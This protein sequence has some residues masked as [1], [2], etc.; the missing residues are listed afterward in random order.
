MYASEVWD[1]NCKGRNLDIL[2][3]TAFTLPLGKGDLENVVCSPPESPR[4]AHASPLFST[5]ISQVQSLSSFA[6]TT[7]NS[8]LIRHLPSLSLPSRTSALRLIPGFQ[9]AKKSQGTLC[10][11]LPLHFKISAQKEQQINSYQYYNW[12]IERYSWNPI[13]WRNKVTRWLL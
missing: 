4:Q 1:S 11:A 7:W 9:A 3:T 5:A 10:L 2:V 8:C 12:G 13:T 6:Y